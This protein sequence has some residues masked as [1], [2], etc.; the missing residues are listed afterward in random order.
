MR[1]K[2]IPITME[3]NFTGEQ[4]TLLV[5]NATQRKLF[6]FDTLKRKILKIFDE[7]LDIYKKSYT[8]DYKIK[9]TIKRRRKAK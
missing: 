6:L 7:H 9:K 4:F 8:N 5:K 3:F 2:L 1:K